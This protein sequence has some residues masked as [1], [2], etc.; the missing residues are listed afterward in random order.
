MVHIFYLYILYFISF[1][2][3]FVF[4]FSLS[5]LSSKNIYSGGGR[6]N[7][8]QSAHIPH[9]WLLHVTWLPVAYF[10]PW[11]A[12]T[13]RSAHLTHL[14]RKRREGG[15]VLFWKMQWR[16]CLN[17]WNTVIYSKTCRRFYIQVSTSRVSW[18][19]IIYLFLEL[20]LAIIHFIFY[21]Q[22]FPYSYL[23]T[24]WAA[25]TCRSAHLTLNFRLSH[26]T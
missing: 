3:H 12:C 15:T 1:S 20:C 23:W 21:L 2:G 24:P 10:Y 5:F 11:A 7:C 25:C 16:Q 19:A 13:C 6:A 18:I 26:P 14:H 22:L 4:L 8:R 9:P 17:I